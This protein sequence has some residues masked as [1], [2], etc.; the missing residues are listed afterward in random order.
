MAKY[1]TDRTDW[2]D[3]YRDAHAPFSYGGNT[4]YE[5]GMKFLDHDG[6]VVEDWG[7]GTTWAK[8]FLKYA[9]YRGIDFTPSRFVDHVA[10]LTE[11]RSKADAIFMRGVLEHNPDW[12][13]ILTNARESFVHRLVVVT[14]IPFEDEDRIINP[15]WPTLAICG[16][17][18]HHILS[19]LTVERL[20]LETVSE[21]GQESV[22]L[23]THAS[24]KSGP[25]R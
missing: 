13:T 25:G 5:A 16:D 12:R 22:F 10:D 8:Q 20:D 17:D 4:A 19:D 18:F 14:F 23:C 6:W 15:D 2:R 21:F 11:Y 24:K 7:C 1:G 9:G 3:L